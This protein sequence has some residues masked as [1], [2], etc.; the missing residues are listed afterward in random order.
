MSAKRK[1][2]TPPMP[3]AS[4][5]ALP[6]FKALRVAKRNVIAVW[7]RQAYFAPFMAEKYLFRWM[8][9][10]NNP[11]A[12]RHVLVSNAANY[13]KSIAVKRA[14]QPLVGNGMFVSNGETWHKT[15]TYR[16]SGFSSQTDSILWRLHVERH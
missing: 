3:S 15:T 8:Y 4:K 5:H 10:A 16:Y 12:V 11:D 13:E 6:P 2:L 14:L 1:L 9:V 7:T